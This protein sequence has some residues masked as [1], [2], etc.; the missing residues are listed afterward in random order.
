VTL[1]ENA[2]VRVGEVEYLQMEIEGISLQNLKALPR[3]ELDALL[4][5]G[6]PI[7]FRIGTADVLA[8]FNRL[9]NTLAVNLAHVDGGGEGVLLLV[10][11]A[12]AQYA[13]DRRYSAVLWHVHALNCARPNPRLQRFLHRRGFEVVNHEIHGQVFM[14]LQPLGQSPGADT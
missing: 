14:L 13:V 10:W 9:E 12:V 7:T 11:K 2:K 5:F 8:E 6:R 4:A 1:R 3:S